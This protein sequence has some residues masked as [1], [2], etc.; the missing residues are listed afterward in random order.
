MPK[1]IKILNTFSSGSSG[2]TKEQ[3]IG[4]KFS[5]F[6]RF[7]IEIPMENEIVHLVKTSV[8]LNDHL[9]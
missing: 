3:H 4:N 8:T 7:T 9:Y 2:M 5:F 1:N 6:Q